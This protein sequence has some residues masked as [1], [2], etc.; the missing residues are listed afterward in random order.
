MT[1]IADQNQAAAPSSGFW[2]LLTSSLVSSLIML[3]SNIVAVSLPSMGRS[4]G[5]S[6]T[7]IQWVISAYVLTYASLLLASG[8]YADLYGRKKAM[9]I[10]LLV[11]AVAS[12]GCGLATTSTLLN[13]ARAVQGVG[14]ALLLTASLAII[15]NAFKGAERTRAFA[16]WGASL[17]IALA[18]GP[19]VGGVITSTIGWRWVFL[20]NIPACAILIAATFKFIDESHDPL[21]K[22]LDFGGIVT[23]SGGLALMVWALI[24][25]N[26]DGWSSPIILIR[27][28]AAAVLFAA[29]VVIELR[30]QH[31][32]VDFS[33]F[34]KDT[35][36]GAVLAMIGYGASAQVMVFFLPLFIQ[37][38]Y[39]FK[40]L[41]AGVA[42]IP[43]AIPMV[44][45]PRVTAKLAA[46]YSGRALLVSGLAIALAGNVLFAVFA[47][48]HLPY[49]VFV[50]S[51]LVA[52]CGAG[53]LNGQT[54]KVLSGAVPPD[55]AGMASGLASTTR[56]IGIL[57]S[58]AVLGA[59]LSDV[60]SRHFV[61]VATRLG[62]DE[63]AAESAAK[64]VTSGDLA[65][66][67]AT[68]PANLRSSLKQAGLTAYSSGFAEASILAALIAAVACA[69][70]FHYV[71][72]ADTAPAQH[73]PG[74]AIPCHTIDCKDPL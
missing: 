37:N 24:D 39:D 72:Y 58:V 29:F 8:N 70:T 32:M 9:V 40:P 41:I 6:F 2:I 19:I 61:A 49:A 60:A 66:M 14:G 34:K 5:A 18:V 53:L 44:M 42:M 54:V 15:G 13:I 45:A 64:K 47:Y 48:Y 7:D 33:L 27:S 57:V 26:D 30:T 31:A 73:A 67:L 16:F 10:G 62:L 50:V 17:G 59:I 12:V 43:F 21:A 63:N 38:S 3:D 4:L 20:V 68:V 65:S 1:A 22:N 35:F 11:F 28:A 74:A 71:R 69:L 52:G 55:R 25:G 46:K 36:L 56:F 51:M 23:F